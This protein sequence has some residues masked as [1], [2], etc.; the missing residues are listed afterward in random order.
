ML[1]TLE[2]QAEPNDVVILQECAHNSTG[3]DLSHSQWAG[4]ARVTKRKNL[5]IVFDSAYQGV[6]TGDVD[7]DTWT[8][9]YCVEQLILN[10]EVGI[11]VKSRTTPV[12]ASPN[13]SPR[14]SACMASV[15]EQYT[16]LYPVAYRPRTH[17][18]N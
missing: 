4:V 6:A 11:R 3:V 16:S 5:F 10:T 12:C 9:R 15:W 13:P 14:I 1:S 17:D 18:P 7:G 2:K 8:V